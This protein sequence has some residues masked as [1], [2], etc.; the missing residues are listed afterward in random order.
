ME[1]INLAELRNDIRF[2]VD[3]IEP[4]VKGSPAEA[5]LALIDIAEA[6]NRVISQLDR[7]GETRP[8][9]VTELRT[10]LARLTFDT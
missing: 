4:L 1:R 3:P 6:A 8:E 9:W 2:Y 10:A 5:W 7:D